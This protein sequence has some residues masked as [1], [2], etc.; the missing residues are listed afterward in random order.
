[1]HGVFPGTIAS[2]TGALVDTSAS[3]P[4][5]VPNLACSGSL[6]DPEFVLTAAHCFSSDA[7]G[8]LADFSSY[9]VVLDDL[10]TQPA[11]GEA[12]RAVFR[13]P[14]F[15]I[16]PGHDIALVHLSEPVNKTVTKLP[17][18]ST[19]PPALTGGAPI[20]VFGWG[21]TS[22]GDPAQRLQMATLSYYGQGSACKAFDDAYNNSPTDPRHNSLDGIAATELC[23][24]RS[25]SD[26]SEKGVCDGDSGG[27]AMFADGGTFVQI[28]MVARG[29]GQD[30]GAACGDDVPDIFTSVFDNLDFIN[31]TIAG[32]RADL[33]GDGTQETTVRLAEGISHLQ[34]DL[35]FDAGTPFCKPFCPVDSKKS[36][37]VDTS[38]PVLAARSQGIDY[39]QAV[40]VGR[41]DSDTADDLSVQVGTFKAQYLGSQVAVPLRFIALTFNALPSP[42]RNDGRFFALASGGLMTVNKPYAILYV[43]KPLMGS[44]NE[45]GPSIYV[46]DPEV[47][48]Y[49]DKPISGVK[50]CVRLFSDAD[51]NGGDND[52]GAD[53]N[54][55]TPIASASFGDDA[56]TDDGWYTVASLATNPQ[57][58][59][60]GE[61]WGYRL[62]I[63]LAVTGDSCDLGPKAAATRIPDGVINGFK[64]GVSRS[65]Q[66]KLS[67]T[68][69]SFMAV[70]STGPYTPH[71]GTYIQWKDT[72][73]NGFFSFPFY[74]GTDTHKGTFSNADAD[75][76]DHPSPAAAIGKNHEINYRIYAFKQEA[77][78]FF[79]ASEYPTETAKGRP[80]G[81]YHPNQGYENGDQETLSDLPLDPM[82]AGSTRLH[83]PAVGSWLWDMVFDANIIH[84]FIPRGSPLHLEYAGGA[85]G[86]TPTTAAMRP[87]SWRGS[88][89]LASRLPVALGV[90]GGRMISVSSVAQ[91]QSL[92]DATNQI[93]GR[94]VGADYLLGELL[95]AKLNMKL[96][97]ERKED[98]GGAQIYGTTLAV[99]S[100]VD[101][102]DDLVSQGGSAGA[103][104]VAE[105]AG[106]LQTIN[107]GEVTYVALPAQNTGDSDVDGDGVI[108]NVDNCPL[109]ANPDQEDSDGNGIGDACEPTPFVRCV[110][111]RQ[112][113]YLAVF[114]YA[115]QYAD[116]RIVPGYNN[117]F[118]PGAVGRGQPRLQRLGG[119]N[120]AVVVPFSGS[121]TWS[122]AGHSATANAQSPACDGFDIANVTF[123]RNVAL[124]ASGDLRI[125]DRATLTGWTTVA[126]AGSGV[127][128]IGAYANVGDVLSQASVTVRSS[129]TVSGTVRTAGTV[130]TQA[131][132]KL[133]GGKEEHV[134]VSLPVLAWTPSFP[135][136]TGGDVRLEPGTPAR[137][138]APG[139]YRSVVLK[140]NTTMILSS[141]TYYM[142]SLDLEPSATLRLNHPGDPVS[143]YVRTSLI[144]RSTIQAQGSQPLKLFL[145]YFGTASAYLEAPITAAVVAPN[146]TLVLGAAKGA[147]YTGSFFAKNLEVRP[148]TKVQ[149]RSVGP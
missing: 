24:G 67:D 49:W 118:V 33:N 132:A 149:Y 39:S 143:I 15:R 46:F 124:Y 17:T 103:A 52:V 32:L 10:T 77:H 87:L 2:I 53:G 107:A 75:D 14:Q 126:N 131:G 95:A 20:N 57:E 113:D 29:A 85:G 97:K 40:S 146:T 148:D 55:L 84:L 5:I 26:T 108:A 112:S 110:A 12:I 43:V 35:T 25:S 70:D 72:N 19:L 54:P 22:T 136:A 83:F 3:T 36:F 71:T 81:G 48:G 59:F 105:V 116:R 134:A 106:Q 78:G 101:R 94:L 96:A 99:S 61:S 86:W 100:V 73:Y 128:D 98:I 65:A 45:S 139:S 68:D 58:A 104:D 130:T 41:L 23:I 122:L 141:G 142:D 38:I 4:K 51:T 30:K 1:M 92:L 42:D 115:N 127:S 21:I 90:P 79:P 93:D 9:S 13:H 7:G 66:L 88:P 138:I 60:N 147:T 117:R 74:V 120:H 16:S 109:V 102:A 137:S 144:Y 91:A 69:F 145:G 140:S 114:G 37:L 121:I 31:S 6:I 44:L 62:E 18:S 63:F 80:S 27:P 34:L 64:V 123:G 56:S 133:L 119:E 125:G 82:G 28:G 129:G 47:K 89:G 135:P 111:R 11:G 50:T 8:A 76:Q